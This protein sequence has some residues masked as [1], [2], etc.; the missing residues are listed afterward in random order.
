MVTF[1]AENGKE[2]NRRSVGSCS[3]GS[4]HVG[5]AC[6][7]DTPATSFKET[8]YEHEVPVEP[9]RRTALWFSEAP[10]C[11]RELHSEEKVTCK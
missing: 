2:E 9:T 5:H 7:L 3:S 6:T 1:G 10:K 11:G 4:R 8:A